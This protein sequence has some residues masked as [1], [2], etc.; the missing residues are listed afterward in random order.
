[1]PKKITLFDGI[2]ITVFVLL[3]GSFVIDAP[4]TVKDLFTIGTVIVG[5]AEK[6]GVR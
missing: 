6:L 4:T 1:M 3:V 2:S 5:L